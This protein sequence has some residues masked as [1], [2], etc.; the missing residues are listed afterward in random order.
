LQAKRQND[1]RFEPKM[2]AD[3]RTKR[4]TL[5]SRAIERSKNWSRE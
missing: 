3:E 5:W 1:T 4:R 2:P